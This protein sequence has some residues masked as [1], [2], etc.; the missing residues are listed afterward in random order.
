MDALIENNYR[1]WNKRDDE[2]IEPSKWISSDV[3]VIKDDNPTY[4]IEL[5]KKSIKWVI[6]RFTRKFCN[7]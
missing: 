7:V 5:L 1:W 4:D 3:S 2:I 6:T